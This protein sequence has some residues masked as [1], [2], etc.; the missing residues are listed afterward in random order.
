MSYVASVVLVLLALVLL[1]LLA[2]RIAGPARRFA[3]VRG[4]ATTDINDRIRML[5]AR[6]AALRVRLQERRA[7]HRRQTPEEGVPP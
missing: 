6:V 1:G 3:V 4:E 5:T 7:Y 2:G